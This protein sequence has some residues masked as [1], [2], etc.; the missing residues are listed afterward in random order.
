M[1]SLCNPVSAVIKVFGLRGYEESV[2]LI[3]FDI[4]AIDANPSCK[5]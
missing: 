3:K 1:L 5:A 2:H 4:F